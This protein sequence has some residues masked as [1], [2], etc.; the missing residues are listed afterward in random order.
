M[1]GI[2]GIRRGKLP[3]AVPC[4]TGRTVELQALTRILD[5]ARAGTPGAVVISAIGGTAGVG[6]SAR[7]AHR[8]CPR[9]CRLPCASP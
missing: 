6:K 1:P 9:Q 4:F 7:A 8:C 5:E 3:S 2:T